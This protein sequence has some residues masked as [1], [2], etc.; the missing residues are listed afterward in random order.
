MD[1]LVVGD[2][3]GEKPEIPQKDYDLVL[4]V[5]DICGGTEEMR[6]HMFDSRGTDSEWYETIGE[7]KA[8]EEVE[9]SLQEGKK[10]L[11]RLDEL[12]APVLVVPG[13][14][15][16]N[17]EMYPEWDYLQGDAFAD[18]VAEFGNVHM[19]DMES[20][21]VGEI[22]VIGYGPCSSPELPQYEDDEPETPEEREEMKQEYREIKSR[23]Q[24]LLDD[25]DK[26][27]VLVSHNVPQGTILDR[28]DNKDSPVHGRHYGSVIVRE[29]LNHQNLFLSVAGHI[30]E[31]QGVEEVD[32]VTC[33]NTGLN[34]V[35]EIRVEEGKVESADFLH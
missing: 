29:L 31:G 21:D 14:W 26:P 5:G 4:A 25:S 33:M 24:E 19:V 7:E 22:K 6:Q 30:H 2:C 18:M 15:D 32:G 34:N 17:S 16:W 35:A 23:L 1:I 27:V 8:R 12:D 20:F 13:N 10:I 3:H 11:E 9:K 28:I